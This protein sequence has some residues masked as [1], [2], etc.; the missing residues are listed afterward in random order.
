[1]RAMDISPPTQVSPF[2]VCSSPETSLYDWLYAGRKGPSSTAVGIY[3]V[4]PRQSPPAGSRDIFTARMLVVMLR[5]LVRFRVVRVGS[6]HLASRW[7]N[8]A[9]KGTNVTPQRS[10]A[11]LAVVVFDFDGQLQGDRHEL[12]GGTVKL[13][14]F[15]QC[16]VLVRLW[17]YVSPHKLFCVGSRRR[18]RFSGMPN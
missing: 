11:V 3:A 6:G 4:V 10:V 16:V 17:W 15:R 1:M 7:R 2:P 14:Y 8:P 18:S 12:I 5:L 13:F 9:R